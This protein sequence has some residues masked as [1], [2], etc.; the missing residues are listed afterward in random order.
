MS[1]ETTIKGS[2]IILKGSGSIYEW[3][4]PLKKGY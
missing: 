2:G 3:Q 4:S 1:Y